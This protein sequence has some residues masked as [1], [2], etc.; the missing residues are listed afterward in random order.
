MILWQRGF[1]QN[2][3]F[4]KYKQKLLQSTEKHLIMFLQFIDQKS[5]KKRLRSKRLYTT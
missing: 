4:K 5:K 2:F 1:K 3:D